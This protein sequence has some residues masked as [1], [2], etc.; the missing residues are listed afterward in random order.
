MIIAST[1][2]LIS[3]IR[4]IWAE[5]LGSLAL[6]PIVGSASLPVLAAFHLARALVGVLAFITLLKALF[7]SASVWIR[8]GSG[9]RNGSGSR[10]G[11]R[12]F[13]LVA[14]WRRVCATVLFI[15]VG[16]NDRD[17][18]IETESKLEK[19]LVHLTIIGFSS[20]PA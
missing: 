7:F 2:G 14:R 17:G 11:R 19:E 12:L 3:C 10:S 6:W 8:I 5:D 20:I 18:R 15:G 4:A 9:S 13:S 16:H 1:F